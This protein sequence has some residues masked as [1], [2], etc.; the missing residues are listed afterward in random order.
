M[1]ESIRKVYTCDHCKKKYFVKSACEKHEEWCYQ[2]PKNFLPCFQGC[3]YLDEVVVEI[4][5]DC[6]NP[7][8]PYNRSSK[9]LY[10]NKLKKIMYTLSAERRGLVERYNLEGQDQFPMPKVQCEDFEVYT[11]R[12]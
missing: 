7:Y 8:S 9:T 3:K 4:N 5:I 10:C 11:L 1:K 6:E 12:F 2:N